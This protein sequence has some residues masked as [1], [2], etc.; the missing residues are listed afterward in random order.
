MKKLLILALLPL[1][2]LLAA[3]PAATTYRLDPAASTLTWTGHAE[4]G[5][6]APQGTIR[7]REG[8]IAAEG[9]TVR[10]ARV[11]VDMA[12]IAHDQ[13]QLAEHLRGPDFF[14]AAKFPT[15]VF[16]LTEFKAGQAR[17]T[18]TLKGQTKP[19]AFPVAVEAAPGGGLRL[20]G[21]VSVD[22]TQFGVNYNS[23]SFFQNLGSY[24]IRNDFQ[25]VFDVVAR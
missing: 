14:D 13:A 19:V 11:V 2:F 24:A 22:R 10:A 20:R 6:W 8:R 5:T 4:A 3:R 18:L 25:V 12:T 21:T 1:F 17:G 9:Q 23:A 16:E 7:L 15:A